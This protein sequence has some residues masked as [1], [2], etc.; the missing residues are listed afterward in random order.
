MREQAVEVL[1]AKLGAPSE[2]K[3]NT[4]GGASKGE[5]NPRAMREDR[6]EAMVVQK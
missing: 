3:K 6:K 4:A 1:Q 2:L 5:F